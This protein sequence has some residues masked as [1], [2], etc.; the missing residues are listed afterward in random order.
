[1]YGSVG[2]YVKGFYMKFGPNMII[3][4]WPELKDCRILLTPDYIDNWIGHSLLSKGLL[5]LLRPSH[6]P[7]AYSL[8]KGLLASS[9]A[10]MSL[11][12][13]LGKEENRKKEN[14]VLPT[15]AYYITYISTGQWVWHYA[16]KKRFVLK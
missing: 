10:A 14:N 9:L 11:A 4:F 8:S 6:S 13:L 16:G 1:M 7:K 15:K 2:K 5:A 3:D 12:C